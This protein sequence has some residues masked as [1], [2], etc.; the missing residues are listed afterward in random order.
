MVTKTCQPLRGKKSKSFHTT[1]PAELSKYI[2]VAESSYSTTESDKPSAVLVE[3]S[4]GVERV[5][6]GM[7]VN[8]AHSSLR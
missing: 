6:E 7:S 3:I 1:Q 5:P 4:S 8:C 2:S